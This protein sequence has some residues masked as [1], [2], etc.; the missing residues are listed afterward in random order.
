MSEKWRKSAIR[1]FRIWRGKDNT[2]PNL[3]ML[4]MFHA[5]RLSARQAGK[6]CAFLAIAEEEGNLGCF[7][8]YHV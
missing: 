6:L 3:V 1:S 4:E 8:Y 2:S 5:D 7:D